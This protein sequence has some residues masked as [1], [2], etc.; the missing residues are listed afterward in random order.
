[1]KLDQGE[2]DVIMPQG[3]IGVGN[4]YGC[5]VVGEKAQ[6]WK[7]GIVEAGIW[8]WAIGR[9]AA[10]GPPKFILWNEPGVGFPMEVVD[11]DAGGQPKSVGA[12]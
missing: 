12:G 7:A 2:Y 9:V 6:G 4:L 10:G 11:V 3:T 5:M 1:M 8:G